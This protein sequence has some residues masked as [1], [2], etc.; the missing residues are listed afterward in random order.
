MINN[1]SDDS[2]VC[3]IELGVP[4]HWEHDRGIERLICGAESIS[5]SVIIEILNENYFKIK[6]M[7]VYSALIQLTKERT[8]NVTYTIPK[9]KSYLALVSDVVLLDYIQF[10]DKRTKSIHLLF[11]YQ[12][13]MFKFL[14]IN[15]QKKNNLSN[16][17]HS[18]LNFIHIVHC[19]LCTMHHIHIQ[20]SWMWIV[21]YVCS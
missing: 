14:I 9:I 20:P 17:K 2:I 5:A 3:P 19:A 1:W 21:T 18:N 16:P 15:E 8:I 10:L 4:L 6:T 12:I 11:I 7:P 13:E